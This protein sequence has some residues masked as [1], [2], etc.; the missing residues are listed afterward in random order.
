MTAQNF[1]A[2]LPQF[3]HCDPTLPRTH[4]PHPQRLISSHAKT[5]LPSCCCQRS[6]DLYRCPVLRITQPDVNVM[7]TRQAVKPIKVSSPMPRASTPRPSTKA[8]TPKAKAKAAT[9]KQRSP[10]R[11]P[12]VRRTNN[13]E[14][15]DRIRSHPPTSLH[16][17][18]VVGVHMALKVSRTLPSP[19]SHSFSL[20]LPH[21]CSPNHPANC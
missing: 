17:G 7:Q 18:L 9:P 13:S 16:T 15:C 8:V 10:I 3:L 14:V 20:S 6:H 1:G 11:K 2:K 4:T 19:L 12:L 5:A 21:T